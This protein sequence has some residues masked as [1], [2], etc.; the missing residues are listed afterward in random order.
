MPLA[1]PWRQIGEIV[2]GPVAAPSLGKQRGE[3]GLELRQRLIVALVALDH[4]VQIE[5]MFIDVPFSSAFSAQVSSHGLIDIEHRLR[6]ARSDFKLAVPNELERA[7]AVQDAS[8]VREDRWEQHTC[9]L[10]SLMRIAVCVFCFKNK[11]LQHS[12]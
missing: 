8:A 3:F 12:C 9:A 6:M 7:S 1:E 11:I 4:D 2:A 10:P 5:A